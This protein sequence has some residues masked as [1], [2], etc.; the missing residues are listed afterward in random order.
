MSLCELGA[1]LLNGLVCVMNVYFVCDSV[2]KK[3]IRFSSTEEDS[4]LAST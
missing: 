2:T 3:S 4:S 1:F